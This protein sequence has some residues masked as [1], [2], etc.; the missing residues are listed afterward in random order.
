MFLVRRRTQQRKLKLRVKLIL[1]LVLMIVLTVFLDTQ[2]RPVIQSMA[3]YRAKNMATQIMNQAVYEVLDQKSDLFDNILTI[4][5]N[6]EGNITAVEA[7]TSAINRIQA[8]LSNSIV[9]SFLDM[10][11]RE[12]NVIDIPLGTLLGIQLFSGRGPEIQMK[13]VPNGAVKTVTESKFISAGINQTLHQ[14]VVNVEATVTAIIPGY[15]TSVVVPA[16][17]I[18]AETLIVGSVP[19]AYAQ[20]LSKNEQSIPTKNSSLTAG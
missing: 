7:N 19:N 14:I 18:L 12:E 9:N 4:Q 8:D 5:K 20:I 3:Q 15:T 17:Y 2:L 11:G 10:V 13:I 16:N 6:Q 1:L